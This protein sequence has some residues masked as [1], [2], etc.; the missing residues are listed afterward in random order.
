MQK[1]DQRSAKFSRV[2][3]RG[4]AGRPASAD[5]SRGPFGIFMAEKNVF[6]LVLRG[7][8]GLEGGGGSF[9]LPLLWS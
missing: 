1:L 4:N 2:H 9:R 8:W 7:L 6:L 3:R 5:D